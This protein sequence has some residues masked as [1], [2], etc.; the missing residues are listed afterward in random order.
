MTLAAWCLLAAAVFALVA[1]VL[2]VVFLGGAEPERLP[3]PPERA[4]EPVPVPSQH[5]RA[6]TTQP[7]VTLRLVSGSG[8]RS[9]GSVT[10]DPRAR[11]STWRQKT[12]D[13]MVSVFVADRQHDD[14]TW[15][16]RRVGVE[17]E[18]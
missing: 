18:S 8:R 6:T 17:R 10:L 14:G 9:L 2:A 11:R 16:Y 15:V 1:I 13:G 7:R 4:P 12:D 3:P 5:A